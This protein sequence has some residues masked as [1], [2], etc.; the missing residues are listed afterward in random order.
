MNENNKLQI[1]VLTLFYLNG[2]SVADIVEY[3][4]GSISLADVNEIL[5]IGTNEEEL[6][7]V[8]AEFLAY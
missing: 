8:C 6:D 2:S 4:E 5:K 7:K 3:Y 1:A